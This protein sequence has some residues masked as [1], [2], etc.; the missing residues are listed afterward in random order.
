MASV[1]WKDLD[2]VI[3]DW[4]AYGKCNNYIYMY[5]ITEGGGENEE[6]EAVYIKPGDNQGKIEQ[7]LYIGSHILREVDLREV[8]GI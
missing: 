5:V 3:D 6:V 8:N 7:W 1:H 4:I 2:D